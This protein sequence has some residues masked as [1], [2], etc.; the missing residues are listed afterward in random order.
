MVT[1]L[2]PIDSPHQLPHTETQI[3]HRISRTE[4]PVVQS[5]IFL[6]LHNPMNHIY[7]LQC[8]L[9]N[10]TL[11]WC[12][13][14]SVYAIKPVESMRTLGFLP[15]KGSPVVPV[16]AIGIIPSHLLRFIQIP[17]KIIYKSFSNIS[18]QGKLSSFLL[19]LSVKMEIL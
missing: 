12:T 15:R 8:L 13:G 14:I 4:E 9:W 3:V 2:T 6:N 1:A 7:L 5:I 19:T 10:D 16:K 17:L 18:L 11:Q